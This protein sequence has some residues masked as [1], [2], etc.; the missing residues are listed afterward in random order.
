[1]RKGSLNAKGFGLV[2]ILLV[3]VVLAVA[4]GTGAYVYHKNHK[5]KTDTS[6]TS[7]TASSTH[8]N[9]PIPVD[10]YAGWKQYCDTAYHYCFKYPADWTLEADAASK[11][12]DLGGA[13]LLN[14]AKS[15]QVHYTNVDNRDGGRISFTPSYI[16]KLSSA[17]QDLT[18]VC[19]Y[20][21]S[22]GEA[23][24]Y[25]PS[26]NVV[27]SSLLTT[28]PQTIGQQGQFVGNPVFTDAG[29]SSSTKYLGQ[30]IAEATS[31]VDT[32]A[33][34]NAW[35]NSSDAQTALKVLQSFD[36]QQ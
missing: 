1:M 13:S 22:S 17:N 28:F 12:G 10:P 36:R 30:L 32:T 3:L 2:G 35:L 11:V 29:T 27:D 25:P 20:A 26:C 23:G 14:P 15:V 5:T 33:A 16:Q 19:G 9:T 24:Q 18:A 31:S 6:S 7:K 21:I 8:K 4:G 34:A